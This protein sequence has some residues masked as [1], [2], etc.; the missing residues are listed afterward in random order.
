M[1]AYVDEFYL[2][3][4]KILNGLNAFI[5]LLEILSVERSFRKN[6]MELTPTLLATSRVIWGKLAYATNDNNLV[7]TSFLFLFPAFPFFYIVF[8][9]DFAF[10]SGYILWKGCFCNMQDTK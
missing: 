5:N 8:R 10:C 2:D 6:L 4:I 9:Q 7:I 1:V 3:T